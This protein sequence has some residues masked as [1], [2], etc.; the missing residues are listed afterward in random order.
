MRIGILKTGSVQP[1]LVEEFG[2]YPD[3]IAKYFLA[4]DKALDFVTY[5]V[6]CGQYP[7]SLDE[8]DAYVITGSKYSVYDDEYWIHRL[9]KFVEMLHY[10]QK[11]MI[12]ICFGHQLVAEVLGG[13]VAKAEYGWC[14]G[15]QNNQISGNT[16]RFRINKKQ[17]HLLASHQDQVLIPAENAKV[18]AGNVTCPISMCMLGHHILTIQGHPE[19]SKEFARHL[20]VMRREILGESL[21]HEAIASL[22]ESVDNYE[23]VGWL[24]DFIAA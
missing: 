3:M 21:Y 11:K 17:F 12:G 5:D 7:L 2:E 23:V 16:G 9:K 8:V 19:F 4:V 20:L 10:S 6:C 1:Q 13:K 15:V 18:L 24:L 14:V 22:A